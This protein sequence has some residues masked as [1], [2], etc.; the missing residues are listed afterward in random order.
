L[1]LVKVISITADGYTSCQNYSYISATGHYISE[2]S[3][4]ISFCLGFAYVNGRHQT[5]NLKEALQKIFNNF[6]LEDKIMGIVSDNAPNIRNFLNSLKIC[7]N[8]EPVRCIAHVLQFIVKNVID[9]VDEGE[10]DES[11]KFYQIGQTFTKCR[12]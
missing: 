8:I 9:I 7:M 5:D 3:N 4:F 2:K 12:K 6:K 10:K 1:A 11:S